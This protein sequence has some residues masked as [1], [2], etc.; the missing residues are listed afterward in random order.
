MKHLNRATGSCSAQVEW[1]VSQDMCEGPK[2]GKVG[3]TP[4]SVLVAMFGNGTHGWSAVVPKTQSSKVSCGSSTDLTGSRQVCAR[5]A[6]TVNAC[7]VT[8]LWR[9]G[10]ISLIFLRVGGIRI[11]TSVRTWK[12]RLFLRALCAVLDAV[13]QIVASCHRSRKSCWCRR[14]GSSGYGRRCDMQR[15][16][17]REQW[18][19]LRF[20]SS[21]ELVDIFVRNRDGHASAEYAG[22]EGFFC[23][24]FAFLRFVPELSASS[25]AFERSHL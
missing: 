2:C 25:R 24:F 17:S 7:T 9:F 23:A 18:K 14:C 4:R 21:P 13:E 8:V 11:L 16:L 22:E 6:L 10:R 15:Q 3:E 20:S 12:I 19:C 1:R 5:L